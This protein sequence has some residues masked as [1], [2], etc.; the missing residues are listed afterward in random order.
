MAHSLHFAQ[1]AGYYLV[2]AVAIAV[3]VGLAVAPSGRVMGEAKL[4]AIFI[5]SVC[6]ALFACRWPIFLWP[7]PINVDEGYLIA[8]AM[9]A[10]VDLLPWHG[11]DAGTSGP[12]N[13]DVLA[14]AALFGAEIGFFSAR[15]IGVCLMAGAI[16]SLYYAVKWIHGDGV[17]RLSIVP[18]VLLLALT[19]SA[20]FVHYSSEHL[21]I[22][23]T[24]VALAAAAYLG[25]SSGSKASRQIACATVGLCLGCTFLAKLQALPIGLVVLA[26]LAAG[27]FLAPSRSSK[28]RKMEVLVAGAGLLAVPLLGSISLSVTGG[29]SDA[30]ISYYEMALV[31]VRS[32]QPVSLSF[33]FVSVREYMFFL[34]ASFAVIVFAAV[35]L[36]SGVKWTRTWM[37]A[38]LCS[39]LLLLASLFAIYHAHRPYPHYLL[40]SVIPVSFCVAD[41]LGVLHRVELEKNR[42]LLPRSLFAVLFF[43]PIGFASATSGSNF[44]R[45]AMVPTRDEVLAIARYAKPGDRMVVWAWQPDYYVKT[46]TIMATRDAGIEPLMEPTPYREYFRERFL[47]DLRA[48]PPL[49]LVDAVAPQAFRYNDRAT[50]GIESFPDLLAFVRQCYEQREEVAGVRIFVAKN[51]DH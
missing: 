8:N 23:L 49:V 38:S 35:A 6:A 5:L 39:I 28:T 20:E 14:L 48:H 1:P 32:R 44:S 15:V 31:Y 27:I 30:V 26:F 13:C 51:R 21:S 17:A 22:F 33:F 12:L 43:L 46:R 11:F 19:K 36:F 45:Q 40:F 9:K 16:C 47:S 4:E 10:R 37:W 18:P 2:G 29:F 50:Q 24:S 3:F 34:V 7:D 25:R 41:A 42:A